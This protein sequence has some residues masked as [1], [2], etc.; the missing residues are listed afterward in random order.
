[1][2]NQ[3][4]WPGLSIFIVEEAARRRGWQGGCLREF[5]FFFMGAQN[6]VFW[7]GKLDR[8]FMFL[9][10]GAVVYFGSLDQPRASF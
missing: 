3:N 4:R 2:K 1:M 10:A 7:S 5:F 8:S 9:H 6:G